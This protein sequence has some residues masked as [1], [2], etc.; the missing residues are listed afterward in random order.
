M[1]TSTPKS[2]QIR[3]MK[4]IVAY[5]FNYENPG[6]K[7]VQ[8]ISY[9]QYGAKWSI[10]AS[11]DWD[12]KSAHLVVESDWSKKGDEILRRATFYDGNKKISAYVSVDMEN[13]LYGN[14]PFSPYRR[15]DRRSDDEQTHGFTGLIMVDMVLS[16]FALGDYVFIW[17][18]EGQN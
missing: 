3:G 10:A 11:V 7:R 5:D 2:M 13:N 9:G 6:S 17:E 16:Q 8:R 1:F 14:F 18:T 4:G 12:G 15:P